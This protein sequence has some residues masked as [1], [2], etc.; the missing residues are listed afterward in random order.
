MDLIAELRSL[1][2]CETLEQATWFAKE[3]GLTVD[4]LLERSRLEDQARKEHLCILCFEKGRREPALE[5][6]HEWS[7]MQ[8]IT[9]CCERHYRRMRRQEREIDL[10]RELIKVRE[11]RKR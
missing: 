3:L 1:G 11:E 8:M 6:C 10:I 4:E 7:G 9:R 5:F 2:V